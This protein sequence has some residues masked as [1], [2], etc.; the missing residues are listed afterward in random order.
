MAKRFFASE[1]WEEDWFLDMPN[2]YKQF[3]FYML[4]KCDHAGVFKVN[5]RSFSGLT[6]VS[7]TSSRALT[8][9]NTGKQRLRVIKEDVW[10]IEDFFVYQ[11][12]QILNLGN[13]LHVS[14]AKI[15]A[16]YDIELTSI[17][18]LKEVKVSSKTPQEEDKDTLKDKD[19]EIHDEQLESGERK[20]VKGKGKGWNQRPGEQFHDLELPEIKENSV[21]ELLRI[22]TG[23]SPT[24]GDVIGLWTVFKVQ[25]FTGE[26]YYQ[27]PEKAFSHFVNWSKQ[28][29]INGTHQQQSIRR[30]KSSGARQVIKLLQDDLANDSK[31]TEDH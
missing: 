1:I 2:E 24:R 8:L 31:R 16:K 12:G 13:R 26:N 29:K 22:A 10:L 25:N 19:K 30:D 18:G 5:L 7:L 27:S 28:Q 23:K 20:G 3:W 6:G 14:I 11:Y 17:R 21:M 15:Y 9:I 4:A